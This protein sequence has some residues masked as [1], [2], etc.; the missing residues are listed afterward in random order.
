M[1]KFVDRKRELSELNLLTNRAVSGKSQ[2]LI[3]YGR[4]RVGKTTLLLHWAEQWAEQRNLPVIYW[5]ARREMPT[6]TRQSLANAVWRWAYPD[7]IDPKP[8]RFDSWES[9]FTQMGRMF[10]DQPL[11]LIMDEFSYAA[12]S[13]PSLPSHLQAAWDHIFK[14]RPLFM[15]LAGSHIGMM[16]DML[17]Y[18]AP[19]YGR[20]TGQLSLGPLPF[21]TVA[22]FF[23]NYSAE[24]RVATYAILGGVAGYW[25][26]FDP[27]VSLVDNLRDHLFQKIGM[28]RS[29]PTILIGDVVREPRTYES[30]LQAIANGARTPA[31]MA[32]VTGVSSPNLSPYLKRLVE[33]GFV[34]RRIPVTIP[35]AKRKSTTRARYHLADP[36]LRFYFRF[37]EPNLEL[38]EQGRTELIW[39]RIREQVRAF[40]GQTTWEELCRTWVLQQADQ[41][42]LPFEVELVGSHWSKNAQIDVVAM[43]WRDKAILLGECKWGLPPVDEAVITKLVSKTDLVIPKGDGGGNVADWQVF[44]IFFARGGYTHA[45]TQA[46]QRVDARLIDLDQVV[47]DLEAIERS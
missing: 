8:P 33:L 45:A 31:E 18:Q 40:I 27:N 14:D 35:R 7:E 44:Y 6:A 9:L 30:V 37:I 47:N 12:E 10:G 1:P 4:R 17:R 43:N 2:F 20:F 19:L 13:D 28:F 25:E 15:I 11:I 36:Y 39:K 34:E 16:V 22:E 32:A 38:I 46:A 24:E 42:N 23:P 41:G 5:V 3:L 29:E 26:R 21:G